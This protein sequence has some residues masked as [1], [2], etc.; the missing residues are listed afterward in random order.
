MKLFK[1]KP[2]M[3]KIL[4]YSSLILFCWLFVGLQDADAQRRGEKDND[5]EYFD[6][7][8]SFKDRLWYGAGGNLG[9]AGNNNSS[10]FLIGLSPMVGYKI[11]EELSVG[12]RIFFNFSTTRENYFG[13]VYRSNPTS[14]GG[15]IF[16]RYKAFQTFFAQA[17][18][19]ISRDPFY[20]V[21]QSGNLIIEN[22]KIQIVHQTS[23]NFYLGAGYHSGGGGAFGYEILLLYNFLEPA[24]T[25]DLPFEL[26]FGLTWGF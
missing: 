11:F 9:F 20:A 19:G 12:P 16:A 10:T 1:I 7:R 6:D 22:N 25:L 13:T 3:K 24:D 8:G 15:G 4:V 14:Y 2:D 18:F 23:E 21:D 17:E 26:R 5:D